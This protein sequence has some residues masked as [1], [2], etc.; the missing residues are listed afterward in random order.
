MSALTVLG[1]AAFVFVVVFTIRAYRINTGPGQTPRGA[2][3]EAWTNI[4]VGFSVNYFANFALLPLVG[5]H[6][7]AGDNFMLGWCYT[8]ISI[9][10]SYALRRF[11]N[12]IEESRR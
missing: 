11:F 2:I 9:I 6:V 3:I 5:V 12:F 4:A 10:R 7:T 1:L 8:A